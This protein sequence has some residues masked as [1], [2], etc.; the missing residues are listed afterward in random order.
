MTTR[1]WGLGLA[2][3]LGLWACGQDLP[4]GVDD[5][6]PLP[7]AG[8]LTVGLTSPND[9]DGG[10]IFTVW[11]M[12]I[13]SVESLVDGFFSGSEADGVWTMLVTGELAAGPIARVHVPDLDAS[14]AVEWEV[15]QAAAFQ[16][17]EQRDVTDYV[18]SFVPQ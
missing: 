16:T 3:L 12:P 14:S 15:Q 2:I 17:Y 8:W 5:G 4:M 18:L 7:E 11:G 10:I 6:A 13:D 9:D 1:I